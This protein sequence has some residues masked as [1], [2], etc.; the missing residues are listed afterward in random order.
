MNINVYSHG[1]WVSADSLNMQLLNSF[2]RSDGATSNGT[3]GIYSLHYA[4][5]K[6]DSG[7]ASGGLT[8]GNAFDTG[9]GFDSRKAIDVGVNVVG[10]GLAFAGTVSESS[11]IFTGI[12]GVAGYGAVMAIKD[13][14]S[15]NISGA[16]A[17]A[18][19]A[20][21]ALDIVGAGLTKF[22]TTPQL[23]AI[24]LGLGLIAKPIDTMNMIYSVL[25]E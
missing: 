15:S 3:A 21:A 16:H 14:N 9:Y 4:Y 22:G 20:A 10:Y 8:G 23:K 24:G 12:A 7:D 5:S 25:P 13:Y 18:N 17:A 1:S 2:Q 19:G 6:G 11:V